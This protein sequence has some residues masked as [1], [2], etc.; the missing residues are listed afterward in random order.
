MTKIP[1][2]KVRVGDQAR[3]FPAVQE[4]SR[5]RLR[6]ARVEART[7][8]EMYSAKGAWLQRYAPIGGREEALI[9]GAK[10]YRVVGFYATDVDP[11]F[12]D[13]CVAV[14]ALFRL[15]IDVVEARGL[16]R[17]RALSA[18]AARRREVEDAIEK[19][20]EALA[21]LKLLIK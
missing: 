9:G 3:V 12:L 13:S 18:V 6:R 4:S 5:F 2:L 14:N 19:L 16:R 17:S 15:D 20:K 21:V 7:T 8:L 11:L 1:V 10:F